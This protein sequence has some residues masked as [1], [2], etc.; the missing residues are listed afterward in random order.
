MLAAV[1][2][3]SI[4]APLNS[5]MIAVALPNIVDEFDTSLSSAT[6]LVP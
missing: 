6:W 2:L 5:T 1:A 4:L 3:I